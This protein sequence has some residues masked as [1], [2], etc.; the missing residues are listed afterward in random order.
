MPASAV[1]RERERDELRYGTARYVARNRPHRDFP[2][3]GLVFFG[4][5]DAPARP[6]LRLSHV[7]W[8]RRARVVRFFFSRRR[9]TR[10]ESEPVMLLQCLGP[11]ESEWNGIS[12]EVTRCGVVG[13]RR[14]QGGPT[15]ADAIGD[16]D[17]MSFADSTVSRRRTRRRSV[18]CTRRKRERENERSRSLPLSLSLSLSLSFERESRMC[19]S[20]PEHARDIARHGEQ[21]TP[22]ENGFFV[23]E[24][25]ARSRTNFCA[26][27]SARHLARRFAVL[28]L[29]RSKERKQQAR[30][31]TKERLVLL[32]CAR[33]ERD[34]RL[35]FIS[36]SAPCEKRGTFLLTP[37]SFLSRSLRRRAQGTSRLSTSHAA[38]S[39]TCKTSA[40]RRRPENMA[41]RKKKR[42]RGSSF[43][44]GRWSPIKS[45]S[46]KKKA[47]HT[48]TPERVSKED[49]VS[50]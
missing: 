37:F 13:G 33:A 23:L 9:R 16:R 48:R 2:R 7:F 39:S 42:K 5:F 32:A 20:G 15:D 29:S 46:K 19:V 27:F 50:M 45:A 24:M 12:F 44:G 6:G 40:W 11:V 1:E 22:F 49:K 25:C 18:R 28:S 4:V 21:Q 14:R 30:L 43:R 34:G 3:E 10:L 31:S 26:T 47:E 36:Y 38:T 8:T 35:A 41:F 17:F